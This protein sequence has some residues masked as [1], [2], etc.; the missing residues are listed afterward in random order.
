M[1]ARA[2]THKY[3]KSNGEINNAEPLFLSKFF[4]GKMTA[5]FFLAF[6]CVLTL[7]RLIEFNF[8]DAFFSGVAV[9]TAEGRF[10]EEHFDCLG[11]SLRNLLKQ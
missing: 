5:K 8:S 1:R 11:T 6:F 10:F 9:I 7:V 4:C 3:V 2:H